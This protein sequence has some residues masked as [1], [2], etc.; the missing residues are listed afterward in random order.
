MQEKKTFLSNFIKNS[1]NYNN[2]KFYD[3][4]FNNYKKKM[5]IKMKCDFNYLIRGINK[6]LN[7]IA[8]IFR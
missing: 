6:N 1:I 8:N 5:S 4:N 3:R 2:N 7:F